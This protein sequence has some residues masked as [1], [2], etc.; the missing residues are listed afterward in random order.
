MGEFK[1]RVKV[2]HKE[3][4][5]TFKGVYGKS[6]NLLSFSTAREFDLFSEAQFKPRTEMSSCCFVE[7]NKNDQYKY[8]KLMK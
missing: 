5:L 4:L 7:N 6:G 1:T 3:F 8:K 2:L